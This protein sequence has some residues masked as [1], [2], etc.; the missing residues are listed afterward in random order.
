ME[1]DIGQVRRRFAL[2]AP[3]IGWQ[4]VHL[5]LYPLSCALRELCHRISRGRR[6]SEDQSAPVLYSAESESVLC[7]KI[8]KW[9]L[10]LSA[11]ILA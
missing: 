7:R 6:S 4:V 8:S 2:S 1:G 5:V 9:I 11:R 3:V 10:G